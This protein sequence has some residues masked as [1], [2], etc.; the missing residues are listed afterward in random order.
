[1]RR[2]RADAALGVLLPDEVVDADLH[3]GGVRSLPRTQERQQRESG[4][5][6]VIQPSPGAVAPVIGRV[7]LHE[8]V[9]VPDAI[10]VLVCGE[11]RER[12]PHGGAAAHPAGM[13]PQRFLVRGARPVGVT[14]LPQ[15]V[16]D[17]QLRLHREPLDPEPLEIVVRHGGGEEGD[18]REKREEPHHFPPMTRSYR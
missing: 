2:A 7:V 17:L 5:A 16:A 12:G 18:E 1:V 4:D 3:V 11:P 10:L 13:D 15:D 9:A 8:L 6:D 14:L